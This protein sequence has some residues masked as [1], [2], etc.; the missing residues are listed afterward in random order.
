MPI[1]TIRR[2]RSKS[3][4]NADSQHREPWVWA[5]LQH[6]L[7]RGYRPVR[8]VLNPD[9]RLDGNS[10]DRLIER[11]EAGGVGLA[12]P[13]TVTSTG[14][15]VYSQRRFVGVAAA[16]AQVFFLHLLPGDGARVDGIIRDALAYEHAQ[17][18]DWL[19]GAC[20]LLRRDVLDEVGGFDER[21]F[22][23]CEDRDLCRRVRRSGQ[24]VVYEPGATAVHD[25]SSSAPS[26]RMV[27]VLVRSQVAYTEKYFDGWRR[28]A[29]R[30]AIA[31]HEA[32]R[33]FVVRG[34]RSARAG[35]FRGFLAALTVRRA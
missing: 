10:L 32:V 26:W 34:G 22:M 4:R 6:R 7:A 23:Y 11:V 30:T 21:F 9:A 1:P 19:S 31:L 17:T 33:V 28:I 18:P 24:K 13:R 35:H 15:L 14:E 16:W 20:M 25:E 5:S 29:V 8:A 27:P 2:Q 3:P 12:A